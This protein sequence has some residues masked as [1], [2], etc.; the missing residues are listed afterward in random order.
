MVEAADI[1]F[2]HFVENCLK[3]L[4][5]SKAIKLS[6][7]Y[8][9]MVPSHN[10]ASDWFKTQKLSS[11]LWE[12]TL[13]NQSECTLYRGYIINSN[14]SPSVVGSF[15]LSETSRDNRA[16]EAS[17]HI[18]H[19]KFL[20]LLLNVQ[21][22]QFH[23]PGGSASTACGVEGKEDDGNGR[24][25]N[26][27]EEH[28]AP[29]FVQVTLA[30]SQS[31]ALHLGHFK[32]SGLC[33]AM[34]RFTSTLDISR[35]GYNLGGEAETVSFAST[36]TTIGCSHFGFSHP[37]AEHAFRLAELFKVHLGQLHSDSGLHNS[38]GRGV[39]IFDINEVD[40]RWDPHALQ[41]TRDSG[42]F[43]PQSQDQGQ[44]L[45]Q[46]WQTL[47][48]LLLSKV[49]FLQVHCSPDITV[50][51]I[52]D[53]ETQKTVYTVADDWAKVYLRRRLQKRIS[54]NLLI[55]RIEQKHKLQMCLYC[56]KSSLIINL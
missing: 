8:T 31:W 18:R 55:L 42:F 23:V 13:F 20:P 22:G 6:H 21:A 53:T 52:N 10:K 16:P 27:S 47:A 32:P 25:L 35:S 37:Q 34:S 19:N 43:V 9:K 15:G 26:P 3:Y 24:G 45:P 48:N 5:I 33:S 1:A 29:Q 2:L 36:S 7:M 4:G 30:L 50:P 49:H 39:K 40:G 17:P 46:A 28:R 51:I 11:E 38:L 12:S 14:S 54:L 56:A 44:G 41:D